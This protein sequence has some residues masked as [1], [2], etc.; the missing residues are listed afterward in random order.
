MAASSFSRSGYVLIWVSSPWRS[1][2][3]VAIVPFASPAVPG[4]RRRA[5][6]GPSRPPSWPSFSARWACG[7]R[8]RRMVLRAG[9]DDL[10]ADRAWLPDDQTLGEILGSVGDLQGLKL[11]RGGSSA[12]SAVGERPLRP[13]LLFGRPRAALRRRARGWSTQRASDSWA[14][15]APCSSARSGRSFDGC[16]GRQAD[17][18]GGGCQ[19]LAPRPSPSARRPGPHRAAV[20]RPAR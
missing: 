4:R 3:S 16:L 11:R 18:A 1:L 15:C 9:L 17:A 12:A 5:P 10:L 7:Q 14:R 6:P 20:L 2:S 13:R 19:S 8:L